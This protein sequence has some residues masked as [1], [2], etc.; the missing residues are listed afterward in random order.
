M[1]DDRLPAD[2]PGESRQLQPGS[3]ALVERD[4]LRGILS[5]VREDESRNADEIDL[6]AYWRMLVKRRWLILSVA[7][8]ALLLSLL[9][10]LTTTPMYR[11]TAVLQIDRQIEQP[12]ATEGFQMLAGA[13]GF[14]FYQ[15]QYELLKSRA[16]AERVADDLNLADP[17]AHPRPPQSWFGRLKGLVRPAAADADA[18]DEDAEEAGESVVVRDPDA[19]RR[20]GAGIIQGGTTIEPVLDSALVKIHFV[21]AVPG[22]AAQAANAVADGFIAAGIERRFEASSYA[23]KYL[24]E[25]LALG[26]TRLEDSERQL[27][28]FAQKEGLP[29]SVDGESLIGQNLSSLNAA[30]AT[31]QQDRIRAQARWDQA[32]QASGTAMPA[33]M[34]GNSILRTLQQQRAQLQGQYQERL[35]VY[36]PDYPAM[37]QLKGQIDELDR[38]ITGELAAIRASVQAEYNAAVTQERLLTGQLGQVR[39]QS[40]DVDERSIQY[41]ILKREVDT[42]R[43]LYDGL[44]Q[45]Y[46]LVQV[47][48]NLGANNI[49]IVDR[50]QVPGGRFKPNLSSNLV[51]GLAIGL[52]LGVLLALVLEFLDDTLKSPEDIEQRLKLAVIGIIPKVGRKQSLVQASLDLRSAFSEA[53][54]S[55]RTA[56]QFSTDHGAPRV[57]L[58]TSP[59]PSEGKSTSALALARNFAQMGRRT[60]LIEGDMR[61]PSL[62]KTLGLLS[63][64]G[65]S[66]VLTGACELTDAVVDAGSEGLQVVFAG[67][68]PPN[69]A[70]LLSG[71]GMHALLEAALA[72]YDQVIIDGPPVIGLADAPVLASLADGVLLVVG[73]GST[74]IA[75]AQTAVKRLLAARGRLIGALLA[76]HDTRSAGYGYGYDGYYGYGTAPRLGK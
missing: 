39:D 44:L 60:L 73:S 51:I 47:A 71:A 27:V 56:L 69:P 48:S 40:L 64:S 22:F 10:T 26:K 12:I 45:R 18:G 31:A 62:A 70:E 5:D 8:V 43:Q 76:R 72:Q 25:Q 35:Q 29:L 23:Q 66:N 58:I 11:A 4:P 42:N 67:P 38:Q 50:A 74:R 36:K 61:N 2:L 6:L 16:L 3:R 28:D 33:D 13:W 19:A 14:D 7:A 63:E 75:T 9:A 32:R 37:L 20:A 52:I 1:H 17:A 54:R 21:S 30:L 53:Y 34:L 59:S 57:L 46:K 49:S 68:L 41:N 24:Q 55:A 15:T 65:L